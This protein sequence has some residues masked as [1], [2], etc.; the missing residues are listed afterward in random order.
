MLLP[1]QLQDSDRVFYRNQGSTRHLGLETRLTWQ[2]ADDLQGV[3]SY[4]LV[5]AEF[6][7]SYAQAGN[8][9]LKNN[10]VPGIPTHHFGGSF[11]WTPHS[12]WFRLALE[13]ADSYYVNNSNTFRNNGYTVLNFRVSRP[14]LKL[15]ST[16]TLSPFLA[17]NNLADKT[18]N[19]SV[20]INARGDRYYEPAAG[21]NFRAGFSLDI[22]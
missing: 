4:T 14:E 8:L 18:Y 21:R 15:S 13:G 3:V 17:L 2:A 11:T 10:D 9:S 22:K 5:N 6:T 1:Y 7:N 19:G 16:I 20:S 12:W